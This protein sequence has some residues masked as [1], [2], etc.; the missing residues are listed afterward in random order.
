MV[1]LP[2]IFKK[3]DTTF[4]TSDQAKG[5]LQRAIDIAKGKVLPPTG[6]SELQRAI[7]L[8]KGNNQLNTNNST[9]NSPTF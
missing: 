6:T 7:D 8:A 1:L 4:N 9:N 3:K 2:D 5:E